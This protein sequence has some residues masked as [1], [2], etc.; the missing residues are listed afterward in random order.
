MAVKMGV[1]V[2]SCLLMVGCWWNG[3][4]TE[5]PQSPQVI[6]IVITPAATPRV[7]FVP[8]PVIE[9][10]R[11]PTRVP[12]V[13]WPKSSTYTVEPT[14]VGRPS[15]VVA[16]PLAG[17]P[18]PFVAHTATPT[19]VPVV[20]PTAFVC[21]YVESVLIGAGKKHKPCHTPT[22]TWTYDRVYS[23]RLYGASRTPTPVAMVFSPTVT[24]YPPGIVVPF[25]ASKLIPGFRGL[26][27]AEAFVRHEPDLNLRGLEERI[28]ELVNLE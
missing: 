2:I 28:I 23:P 4:R 15:L 24:P 13:Q 16:S 17:T 20:E 5:A 19:S 21:G 3:G 22:P 18:T 9:P 11:T 8:T 14:S 26:S 25:S 27:A 6:V 12:D 7:V 1:A 10:T